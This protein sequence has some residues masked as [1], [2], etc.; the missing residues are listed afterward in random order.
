MSSTTDIILTC[1][2]VFPAL[3]IFAAKSA[4]K[5]VAT[6]TSALGPDTGKGGGRGGR[7][8]LATG[9]T[10]IVCATTAMKPSTWQPKSSLT[11]SPSASTAW[12]SHVKI[13]RE[14]IHVHKHRCHI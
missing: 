8:G 14:Y 5:Y 10:T 9:G 13:R 7:S 11:I 3:I 1:L 6:I 12:V 4:A 2:L